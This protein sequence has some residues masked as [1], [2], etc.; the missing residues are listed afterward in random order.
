MNLVTWN[1]KGALDRKHVALCS[2]RPDVA[3]LPEAGKITSLPNVLG[4]SA[5]RSIQWVGDNPRKGLAVVSYG[6]YRLEVHDSY[7]PGLR[8]ILPLAV[9]GPMPFVLFAVWAMPHPRYYVQCLFEAIEKYRS[10]LELPRVVWAGDF[11]NNVAFDRRAHELNF[12]HWLAKA[13]ALGFQSLYHLHNRCE[14]GSESHDTFFLHHDARKGHH[15]DFIFAK[16]ALYSR[17]VEVS[18]G[19]PRQWL[20]KSDHMPVSC[21]FRGRDGAPA[22]NW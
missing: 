18:I 21:F 9:D 11:N 17:G 22:E 8:W 16:P 2:L 19:N 4:S 7:D 14:H 6:D 13:R 20:E 15:L 12:A 3:V 1:C 5:V 10:V